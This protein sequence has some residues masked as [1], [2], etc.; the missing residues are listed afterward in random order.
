MS[1][2]PKERTIVFPSEDT[3]D[4]S[5]RSRKQE[6]THA[7]TSAGIGIVCGVRKLVIGAV[8]TMGPAV[9]RFSGPYKA[10][11]SAVCLALGRPARLIALARA[12]QS[13]HR[14][15]AEGPHGRDADQQGQAMMRHHGG[16]VL[17]GVKA[18]TGI[19]IESGAYYVGPKQKAPGARGTEGS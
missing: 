17:G 14:P 18:G 1:R 10:L 2:P 11:F 9:W 6:V 13:R 4:Q 3:D 19:A 8:G 5:D 7:R 12:N 16:S 15:D